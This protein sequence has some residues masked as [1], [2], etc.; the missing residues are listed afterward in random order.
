MNIITVFL[1]TLGILIFIEILLLLRIKNFLFAALALA[2][3][4]VYYVNSMVSVDYLWALTFILFSF[5]LI[6][7]E[8]EIAAGVLL[9][10]ATGCRITS[11]AMLLPFLI[12]MFSYK[13]ERS[14]FSAAIKFSV[15]S[16]IASVFVFLPVIMQYGYSFFDYYD[17]IPKPSFEKSAFKATFGVFGLIGTACIACAFLYSLF[18]SRLTSQNIIYDVK[19]HKSVVLACMLSVLL[20]CIIYLMVPAKSAYMIPLLP[21]FIILMAIYFK[22]E[23]FRFCCIS[24]I[25]SPFF[26]GINLSDPWRGADPSSYSIKKEIGGQEIFVDVLHGPVIDE[27]MKRKKRMEFSLQVLAVSE[28]KDQPSVVLSGWWLNTILALQDPSSKAPVEYLY[29]GCEDDLKKFTA[30][31]K[32][33]FFLP[34]VDTYNDLRCGGNFTAQYSEALFK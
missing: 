34:D 30:E 18:V 14:F 16:V 29:Y 28:T 26:F 19:L 25:S 24:L 6:I 2:F 32:K 21:F 17:L 11:L 7:L 31:G 4:P 3:T 33:V 8:K 10:I 9:G 22:Q 13:D 27:H 23:V 15:A 5:Y 1:S 20:T 12:F